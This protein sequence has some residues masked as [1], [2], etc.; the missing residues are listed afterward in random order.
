MNGMSGDNSTGDRLDVNFYFWDRM[1]GE[2]I[3]S[4]NKCKR[5][6]GYTLQEILEIAVESDFYLLADIAEN[7][8][9]SDKLWVAITLARIAIGWSSA[10]SRWA[11][12]IFKLMGGRYEVGGD[13]Y[14]GEVNITKAYL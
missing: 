5:G 11:N 12:D 10:P 7:G 6:G 14:W 9:D 3:K 1:H 2:L 13:Y 8:C 4:G